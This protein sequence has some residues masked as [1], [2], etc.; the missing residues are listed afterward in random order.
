MP[1][2]SRPTAALLAALLPVLALAACGRNERAKGGQSIRDES[3]TPALGVKQDEP[4][5]VADLGFPAFATK[6]TTRIGGADPIADAAGAALATFPAQSAG[7]RPQVVALADA[8]DWRATVL[9]GVLAAEPIGAAVLLSD[10]DRLP[11]A[12]EQA[13]ER[14]APGGS[15]A[16]GG[17]QLIRVG[18][19]AR[20]PG[21]RTTDLAGRD[22]FA[23]AR[24]VDAFHAAASGRA[25]DTVVVVGAGDP[26]FAMPAAAWA[27][28]SGEPILLTE[29]D[30]LPAETRR[31]LKAHREPRIFVL[32]PPSAVSSRVVVQLRRL[33]VVRRIGA[34]DPVRNAI[35]FARFSDSGFGWGA[36]DPGHGLT[37][38]RTDRPADAA[39]AALLGTHGAYAPLL[40]VGDG[41]RL[42]AA[43]ESYLLDIQPGYA[44]DPVRG[45]YNRGWILGD[46]RALS[47]A[48]QARIDALLEIQPVS[49]SSTPSDEGSS[50]P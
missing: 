16:V 32:G 41:R 40:L 9:A 5:A 39:A 36:V 29:R 21:L 7:T 28:K 2:R 19:A 12:T 17:A 44:R 50:N 46:D 35:E 13:L 24:A 14:L 38:A 6:N 22:T 8:R 3:S 42:D 15:P 20:P 43:V 23:L 1:G 47:V 33:G 26:A 10:G 49:D 25:S 18:G 45:V 30:R 11:P 31:A 27:A 4:A 37:F 34:P 48:E